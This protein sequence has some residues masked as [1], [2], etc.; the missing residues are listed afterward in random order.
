[1]NVEP[2]SECEVPVTQIENTHVTMEIRR[3]SILPNFY[4][5]YVLYDFLLNK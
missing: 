4:Q 3:V 5:P 2:K 1:M